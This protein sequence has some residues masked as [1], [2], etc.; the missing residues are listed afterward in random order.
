M[1][2]SEGKLSWSRQIEGFGKDTLVLVSSTW[3]TTLVRSILRVGVNASARLK[4][5]GAAV[6]DKSADLE[7][8]THAGA[9]DPWKWSE[10]NLFVTSTPTDIDVLMDVDAAGEK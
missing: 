10:P 8:G 3:A 9:V 5:L 6:D 2:F 4:L 7:A 1:M